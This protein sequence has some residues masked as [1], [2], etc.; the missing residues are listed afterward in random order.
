MGAH[1]NPGAQN[2]E[3]RAAH[4]ARNGQW[5]Q[6]SGRRLERMGAK[7]ELGHPKSK[8]EVGNPIPRVPVAPQALELD[9][10]LGKN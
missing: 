6:G 8:K 1:E 10:T 3:M 4:A 5:P 7:G 2:P 9:G